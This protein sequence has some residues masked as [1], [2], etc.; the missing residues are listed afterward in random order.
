MI[1]VRT[2]VLIYLYYSKWFVEIRLQR[3]SMSGAVSP[4]PNAF[5][6]CGETVLPL[7][8]FTFM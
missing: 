4:L 5:M 1:S 8:N 2:A 6:V 7:P 3:L